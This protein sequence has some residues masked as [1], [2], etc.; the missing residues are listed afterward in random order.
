M[1]EEQKK[2]GRPRKD[3]IAYDEVAVKEFVEGEFAYHV[4]KKQ[5][6]ETHKE[7]RETF[8]ERIDPQLVGQIIQAVKLRYKMEKR[9]ASQDTVESIMEIVEEVYGTT[10]SR[11]VQEA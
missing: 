9:N 8:K 11:E 10:L 7:F 1:S 5:A 2:R 4:E 3:S 6:Q